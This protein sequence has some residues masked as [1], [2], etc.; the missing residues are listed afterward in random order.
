MKANVVAITL[1]FLGPRTESAKTV[2][3]LGSESRAA[4]ASAS[5]MST[6]AL[7]FSLIGLIFLRAKRC[8][9]EIT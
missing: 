1:G 2:C 5:A 7:V 3:T 6:I 8:K 4:G 9:E